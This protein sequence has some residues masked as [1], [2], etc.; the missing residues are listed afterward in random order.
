MIPW[1]EHYTELLALAL[2]LALSQAGSMVVSFVDNVM[3]GHVGTTELAAS[4]FANSVVIV[5]L[6]LGTGILMGITPLIGFYE[7]QGNLGSA[8][9]IAKSSTLIFAVVTA[10]VMVTGLGVWFL[11]PFMGQPEDVLALAKP[12]YLIVLISFIPQL[13]FISFKQ[14]GEGFGNTMYAM[15]AAVAGNVLNVIFNYILIFGKLGFS[16]MGL[17]GAAVGTLLSRIVMPI[18]LVQNLKNIK[19][20]AA[21]QQICA[22]LDWC[23]K[24]AKQ[25]FFMGY[26]IA[27]QMLLE[28]S[29]FTC[30]TIMIG[31][32]GEIPL[33]GHQI[34]ISYCSFT[35]LVITGFGMAATIRV[36]RLSGAGD[37]HEL[38]RATVSSISSGIAFMSLT[39]VLFYFFRRPLSSIF[40]SDQKVIEEAVPLMVI[41]AGF[42]LLDA[43][44]AIG[45]G[46]LRGL[47][48]VKAPMI[49]AGC[50]YIAVGMPVSYVLGIYYGYGTIGVWLGFITGLIV[51]TVAYCV[52][53]CR[54]LHLRQT[55]S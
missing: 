9:Q 22:S 55:L 10:V 20:L 2:P 18:L 6:L 44:Q 5:L 52:R 51:A 34:A 53:I 37:P 19:S 47:H 28:V 24:S 42:Q 45:L 38:W 36:S 40:T 14:I 16:P 31:W 4:S 12:Y 30:G 17:N 54:C 48:D 21:A 15:K 33:A 35:F 43:V 50:S 27:G 49:I 32:I 29:M 26:P 8:A 1:K 7:G 3:V 11:L 39:G 41:A 13:I 46:V 25:I 23:W